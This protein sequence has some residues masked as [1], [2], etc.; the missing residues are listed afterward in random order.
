MDAN[1]IA[2]Y[3]AGRLAGC[4]VLLTAARI[5]QHQHV[6]GERD[7]LAHILRM[8]TFGQRTGSSSRGLL[9][10]AREDR[11]SKLF[12]PAIFRLAIAQRLSEQMVLIKKSWQH[13]AHVGP[14]PVI[15]AKL[16]FR[17]DAVADTLPQKC[18]CMLLAR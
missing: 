18:V 8:H 3:A 7:R 2:M 5:V 15:I 4:A 13:V 16:L 17:V 14:R 1:R 9:A 11:P 6:G 12:H 10:R